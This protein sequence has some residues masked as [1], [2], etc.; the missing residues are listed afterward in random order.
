VK[1]CVYGAGAVGGAL[2]VRLVAAGED[3]TVVA[4]GEH[5][6]AIRARG[7]T[8]TAGESTRTVE[9]RC[10]EHPDALEAAPDVVFVTVKQTQLAAMAAP[11]ARLQ[12]GGA[13]VV[14]AMNGIPWWFADELPIPDKAAFLDTLDPGRTLRDAIDTTRLIGAMVQSSNE[15]VAPGVVVGTT[16]TRN[17]IIMGSVASGADNR[18][19]EIAAVLR[20]AG[21]DA[22]EAPDIRWE[23][24]NKMA[25]WLAVA[26]VSALTGLALDKL[27]GD[28]GGFEVMTYIMREANAIGRRLGFALADD[29]EARIGFYR[30]KPTRTSLLKDFEQGREPELASGVLVFDVLARAVGVHAPH[31]ATVATLARLKLSAIRPATS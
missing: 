10:V 1:L 8:L 3:V 2:A 11:L 22:A 20:G 7:L 5:G 31:I 16:P 29:V 21:Y 9:V 27:V 30:D 28:P 14:L 19:D 4:R 18:I 17:R 15:I 12:R 6:R 24:W 13:R 25:L 26:P 23:L